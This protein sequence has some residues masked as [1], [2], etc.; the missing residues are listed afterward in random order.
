ML[1]TSRGLL[2]AKIKFTIMSSK[3]YHSNFYN[4]IFHYLNVELTWFTL[5]KDQGMLRFFS[6]ILSLSI[7]SFFKNTSLRMNAIILA[8]NI[9]WTTFSLYSAIIISGVV[10]DVFFCWNI[11]LLPVVHYQ[12]SYL[13][14]LI[15]IWVMKHTR[16]KKCPY[17]EFSCL[18]FPAFRL[19]TERYGVSLK[20]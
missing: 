8:L 9:F 14:M 17:L 7:F 16:H 13:K 10:S 1:L 5:I 15:I 6:P 4:V 19:N 18:Y 11:L 12:T 20:C 2:T 3:L